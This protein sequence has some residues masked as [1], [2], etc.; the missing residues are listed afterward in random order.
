MLTEQYNI[1]H[2]LVFLSNGD[3]NPQ[4]IR[5]TCM[6]GGFYLLIFVIFSKTFKKFAAF[7]F[8]FAIYAT[9]LYIIY[10]VLYI[11]GSAIIK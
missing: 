8:V 2:G 5:A 7:A 10:K 3:F 6:F 4:F 9:F 1:Y 11:I